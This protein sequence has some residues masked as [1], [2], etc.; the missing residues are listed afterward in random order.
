LWKG[1][2]ERLKVAVTYIQL[3]SFPLLL[4]RIMEKKK[5]ILTIIAMTKARNISRSSGPSTKELKFTLV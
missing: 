5:P 1:S 2:K 4:L 3:G